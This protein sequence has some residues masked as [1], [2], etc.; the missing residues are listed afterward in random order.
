MSVPRTSFHILKIARELLSANYALS[1]RLGQATSR[2]HEPRTAREA[3]DLKLAKG[4]SSGKKRVD[5]CKR[6]VVSD[7]SVRK[8][9]AELKEVKL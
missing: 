5:L 7:V 2:E 1:I 6:Q 4:N 8:F 9:T 3:A